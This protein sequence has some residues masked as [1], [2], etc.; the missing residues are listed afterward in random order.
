MNSMV[1]TSQLQKSLQPFIFLLMH[2]TFSGLCSYAYSIN[3]QPKAKLRMVGARLIPFTAT[4]QELLQQ[5]LVT[6]LQTDL[7]LLRADRIKISVDPMYTNLAYVMHICVIICKRYSTKNILQQLYISAMHTYIYILSAIR[8]RRLTL[9]PELDDE[10][11]VDVEI[12]G[13]VSNGGVSFG[14]ALVN[15]GGYLQVFLFCC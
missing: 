13:D 4:K 12:E 8:R 7:P 2:T 14:Q 1:T 5:A 3:R 9:D 6:S 11:T 15:A 10:I